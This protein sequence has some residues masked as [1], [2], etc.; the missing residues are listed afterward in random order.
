MADEISAGK[1][2]VMHTIKNNPNDEVT[3]SEITFAMQE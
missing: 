1:C 2:T 3:S